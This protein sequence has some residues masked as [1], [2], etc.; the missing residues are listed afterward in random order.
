MCSCNLTSET[1]VRNVQLQ[2]NFET[3]VRNVQ[4]Q[5]NLQNRGEKCAAAIQLPKQR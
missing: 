2:F 4:L 3:E 5:F 1:E